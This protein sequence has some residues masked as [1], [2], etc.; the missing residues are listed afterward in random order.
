MFLVVFN[1]YLHKALA[2]EKMLEAKNVEKFI[3]NNFYLKYFFVVWE[4][5]LL[6]TY[7]EVHQLSK[8]TLTDVKTWFYSVVIVKPLL[9]QDLGLVLMS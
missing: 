4:S 3:S 5:Q 7:S 6:K 2:Y 8:S 9:L 1:K